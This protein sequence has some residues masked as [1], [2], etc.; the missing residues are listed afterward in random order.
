ML[1]GMKVFD[2]PAGTDESTAAVGKVS[3]RSWC[4]PVGVSQG[5]TG[6]VSTRHGTCG[7]CCTCRGR[8]WDMGN[9]FCMKVVYA[10][11]KSVLLIFNIIKM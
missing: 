7:D 8:K 5:G 11:S 6:L 3:G 10:F 4:N 1:P 9:M 2:Y